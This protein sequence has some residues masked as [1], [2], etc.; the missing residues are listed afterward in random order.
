M[1]KVSGFI[2]MGIRSKINDIVYTNEYLPFP[3]GDPLKCDVAD[4][5]FGV[6]KN[7]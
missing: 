5:E 1:Y 3:P 4:M 2:D 7:Q 6:D